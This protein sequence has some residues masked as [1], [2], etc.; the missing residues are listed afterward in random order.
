MTMRKTMSL[1]P[2]EFNLLLLHSKKTISP[3]I[4]PTSPERYVF[5]KLHHFAWS[6]D[7]NLIVNLVVLK[8]SEKPVGSPNLY[9]T[10]HSYYIRSAFDFLFDPI[11]T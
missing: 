1:Y 9:A 5:V 6:S 11:N 3:P 2:N 4:K 7:Q 10:G 8:V